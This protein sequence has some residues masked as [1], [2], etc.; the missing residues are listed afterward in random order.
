MPRNQHFYGTHHAVPSKKPW[1]AFMTCIFITHYN[2]TFSHRKWMWIACQPVNTRMQPARIQCLSTDGAVLLVEAVTMVEISIHV[3]IQ[4]FNHNEPK[5]YIIHLHHMYIKFWRNVQ[6]F[7]H[8]NKTVKQYRI[9]RNIIP[10]Q[11][12]RITIW[13]NI[14]HK[15][16]Q[17][18]IMFPQLGETFE[19]SM[20]L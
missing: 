4:F 5:H 19:W 20:V 6:K 15:D 14:V 16:C 2:G 17:M 3:D 12:G 13:Y 7:I 10:Y 11:T 8:K 1:R 18:C 9:K